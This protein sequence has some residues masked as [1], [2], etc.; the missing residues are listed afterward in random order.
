[1]DFEDIQRRYEEL[2][3]QFDAGEISEEDFRDELEGLQLK[4]EFGR[5]WTMGAQTGEWYRFDGRTW[6]QET[7]LPLT[8]HQGRG[9][10]EYVSPEAAE[11]ESVSLVPRWVYTGCGGLL[12]LVVVAGLIVGAVTLLRGREE[13]VG[14]VA[15]P[16]LSSGI[17]A[18]TPTLGPTP[19]PTPTMVA[20]DTPVAP[21]VYSN[22]TFGFSLQYPGDWQVKEMS[23]QVVVAP[24]AQGLSTVLDE[25]TFKIEGV[26]FVV[27]HQLESIS[28]E[29]V[30][31]LGQVIAGLPADTS[32][33]DTGYRTVE[34]VE[35]A[36]SQVKLNESDP[37][38]EMTAYV[39]ATFQNG[40]AYRVLAVAP[41]AEWETLAPIFQKIFDSFQFSRSSVVAMITSAPSKT[42]TPASTSTA[43]PT[44]AVS[45]GP[46]STPKPV[47]YVTEEGD[48]LGAIAI[49]FGVSV[50]DIQSANG[51]GDPALLRVGQELII[52]T[53]GVVP[54]RAATPTPEAETV[55]AATPASTPQPSATPVPIP[56]PTPAPVALAGKIV[57]PVH[58]PN[59]LVQGQLGAYDIWMSDPQ[60][61]NRQLMVADASQPDLSPGGDM[62]AYRSWDPNARG[63]AVMT[64]GAGYGEVLAT[65]LEDGL[66][67]WS[68]D[69]MTLAFASRREGDRIPR[70]YRVGR[71]NRDDWSLNLIGEYVSTFSDGRLV[72]KGCTVEGACGLFVSGPEGGNPSFISNDS[73]DNAPSPSPDGTK[74]AF[75]SASREGAGNW[76]IFVMDA[77]GGNVVRLTNNG[78]NDGLPTWSPDGRT[79]A[80][81]SDRDGVWGIWA[82]NPDGSNQRKLFNMGGSPDGVIGF[83]VNNSKGWLEE[84]ISWGP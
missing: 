35:W 23:S 48:T 59:K 17:P 51:I 54:T 28:E 65:F 33:I 79:I 49:Q 30:R 69:T 82:M 60:G 6:I 53:G 81:V 63:V 38:E 13:T 8:K 20:T 18:N 42:P 84:R 67:S 7:P 11:R 62:L 36:I 46:T 41:S 50:E 76:E 31:L 47:V 27:E 72:Y 61:N 10:P 26:A 77:N 34:Q 71:F 58:D 39:A 12:L 52:P 5:Y 24:D 74:I 64:I 66:P 37:A 80:F 57:F 40:S 75:M 19:S 56:T 2:R 44:R 32:T 25:G 83:D 22:S 45:Q 55:T 15:T 21:K 1:M 70:I 9:L 73:G 4:D 3:E 68:P 78:A 14:Q 16:T 29:P 43:T